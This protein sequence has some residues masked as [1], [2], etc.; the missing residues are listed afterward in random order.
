M[1]Y[2]NKTIINPETGSN[3]IFLGPTLFHFTKDNKT[4]SGLALEL[5]DM[6]LE[7]VNLKTIGTDMEE[8]I[9]KEFKRVIPNIK[10]LYCVRHFKQ[11]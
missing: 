2:H 8:A 6:E 1:C 3:F 4:F 10:V 5:L 9:A 11:R 7:L